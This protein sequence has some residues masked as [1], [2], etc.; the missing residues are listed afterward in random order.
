MT[1][2]QLEQE[3]KDTEHLINTIYEKFQDISE[4]NLN[5]LLRL[6]DKRDK[7]VGELDDL[8]RASA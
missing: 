3:I 5:W 8:N 6:E 1:K 4:E 7:L 2:E